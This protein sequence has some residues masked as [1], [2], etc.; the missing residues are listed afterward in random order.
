MVGALVPH[1]ADQSR[2]PLSREREHG[3]EI[4]LFEIDVQ[5]S[6]DRRAFGLNVGDIEN[7]SIGAP[8][9]AC[10]DDP[11]HERAGAVAPRNIGCRT[12]LLGAAGSAKTRRRK[13]AAVLQGDKL[14]TALDCEAHS[15]QSLDEQ[16]LMLVLRK[17]MEKRIGRQILADGLE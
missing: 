3:Q 17:D 1:R 13:G 14:E 16:P 8:G 11:P 4:G 2:P 10:I 5:L 12:C 6:I 15:F 7:L 9:K